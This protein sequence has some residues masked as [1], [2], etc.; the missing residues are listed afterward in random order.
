MPTKQRN[1][2]ATLLSYKAENILI[3]CGEGT[4]RQMRLTGIKP[5]KITKILISHWHGDH[6]LGLPGLLQTMGASEYEGELMIFGP[7]GSK[8]YVAK[9]LNAFDFSNLVKLKVIEVNKRKFFENDDFYLEALQLDHGIPCLG[10]SFVEKDR[11]RIKVP[12]IKKL[13]MS[14]GPLLGK[15]QDGKDITFKGKKVKADDVTSIV[16]GKKISYVV[17]TI[18]TDNAIKLAEEADILICEA[19]FESKLKN[20]AEEY[21]HLTAEQAGM[22]ANQAGA[23]K[24]IL[25]HF[26]QRYKNPQE[27]EEEARTVFDNVICAE[28]FMKVN[29]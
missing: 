9:M 17:D 15:L 23:K 22:I 24:L 4:Q 28:D 3:D 25:T 26:S 21:K 29:L 12:A 16:T 13:G 19:V 10:F 7:K 27:L 18:I 14:E 8:E 6:V 2:S 20:K 11:R 5:T 1:T